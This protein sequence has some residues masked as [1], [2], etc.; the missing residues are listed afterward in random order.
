VPLFEYAVNGE[1]RTVTA[2]GYRTEGRETVFWE[3]HRDPDSGAMEQVI[4]RV[5]VD[6]NSIVELNR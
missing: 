4:N 5:K 2:D 1:I 3:T 6:A